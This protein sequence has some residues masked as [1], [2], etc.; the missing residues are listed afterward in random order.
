MACARTEIHALVILVVMNGAGL[1]VKDGQSHI[2]CVAVRSEDPLGRRC[3]LQRTCI[4]RDTVSPVASHEAEFDSVPSRRGNRS[5]RTP[6][7]FWGETSLVRHNKDATIVCSSSLLATATNR[8]LVNVGIGSLSVRLWQGVGMAWLHDS[9]T[10]ITTQA[11]AQH[12]F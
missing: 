8:M 5:C 1:F 6:L 10:T 11:V 4:P 12:P 9:S 7:A 3:I 2:L